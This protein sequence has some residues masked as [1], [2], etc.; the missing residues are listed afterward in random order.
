MAKKL[1]FRCKKKQVICIVVIFLVLL[2]GIWKFTEKKETLHYSRETH[3][4]VTNVTEYRSD[5]ILIGVQQIMIGTKCGSYKEALATLTAIKEAGY[6]AVELN[7][8]MIHPAGLSVKLLTKFS[9]MPVGNGGKLDWSALIEESG[10]KVSSFHT[11]L[12]SIEANPKQVAEEALCFGTNTVVITGM[13]RF[14]YSS[15][16]EVERL[17]ER[18]NEAGKALSEYG[19]RLLYHN[20]NCELQKVSEEKTA[21]DILIEETDAAYVNFEF[22]SYWFADGG[23]NVEKVMEK[24]G[25]RMKLWH[26]NDRGCTKAGPYMTPILSQNATELG[27]GNMDLDGLAAI[28]KKN[29]VEAVI[30]ETHKNWVEKNPIKSL[31]VSS[32]FMKQHFK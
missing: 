5:E 32:E 18:L 23:A 11:Y 2:F 25:N 12:D 10:L 6:D 30:L 13:Y 3:T 4:T 27:N 21:Y 15:L 26:I 16:E 8:F 24:L 28:A 19:V 20:H 31:K 9:G 22:D 1:K 14:D 17:A 29:G 7:D